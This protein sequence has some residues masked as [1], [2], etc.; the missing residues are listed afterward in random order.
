MFSYFFC[1]IEYEL[2][3]F[4]SHHSESSKL[5]CVSLELE[6]QDNMLIKWSK[7]ACNLRNTRVSSLTF[8]C[9][10]AY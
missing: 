5:H 6:R 7:C 2:Y 8:L 3:Y 10:F 9:I 1:E 4:I